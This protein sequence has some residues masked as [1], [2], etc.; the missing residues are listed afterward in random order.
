VKTEYKAEIEKSTVESA[1]TQKTAQ[2]CPTS[3]N[4]EGDVRRATTNKVCKCCKESKALSE[5]YFNKT[6]KTYFS[7]CKVCNKNR[8]TKWN[9]QNAEKYKDNC[10][11][12]KQE[13]PE[14]YK[15]YKAKEYAKNK[16]AYARYRKNYASSKHG[17]GIRQAL[18]RE[19][20]LRKTKATPPWLTKEQRRQ[21]QEIYINRPQ[22]YHVDHIMPL[23]G[24]NSCGLHVPW[25]LQYLPALENI[26]KRNKIL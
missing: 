22:G 14:K 18:E 25:N 16:D 4:A 13:N 21:M 26:K 3:V 2:E 11:K 1:S 20:Q 24:K 7:E 23:N 17:R 9:K 19:R 12:H 15:A 5:F 8:S 6:K 10:K